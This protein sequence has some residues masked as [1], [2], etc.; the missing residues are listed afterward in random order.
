M[1]IEAQPNTTRVQDL[2]KVSQVADRKSDQPDQSDN[3]SPNP[4][5]R[6]KLNAKHYKTTLLKSKKCIKITTMNIQ[7]INQMSQQV[8]LANNVFKQFIEIIGILDHKICHKNKNELDYHQLDKYILITSSA[9]RNSKNATSVGVGI[10]VNKTVENALTDFK[11]WNEPIPCAHFNVK[12]KTTITVHFAPVEG[13]PDSE[14]HYK[15]IP[16]VAASIPKH[17][18]LLVIGD[19]NANIGKTHGKLTYHDSTNKN[20]QPM[21]DFAGEANMLV[22]NNGVK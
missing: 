16:T 13:K 10:L 12:P 11:L 9:L 14:K 22:T 19:F 2:E 1:T 4:N 17:N 21:V 20:G 15:N 7:T 8:E 5:G 3:L 6:G 18:A